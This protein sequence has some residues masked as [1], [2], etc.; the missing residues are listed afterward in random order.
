MAVDHSFWLKKIEK[1]DELYVLCS[2]YT[3]HPFVVC[4]EETFDDMAYIFTTAEMCRAFAQQF[5]TDKYVLHEVQIEK[6]MIPGVLTSFFLLGINAVMFQDEGAP[7]KIPLEE[8]A[9]KPDLEVPKNA[10]IPEAN[11]ELQLTGLYFMQELNRPGEKSAE[12]KIRLSELEAEMAHY[13][14]NSR[15]IVAF[16]VT[17]VKGDWNPEDPNQQVRV[18]IVSTPNGHKFQPVYTDYGEMQMFN[19]TAIGRKFKMTAVPYERLMEY[20]FKEAEGFV[21]NPGGFNLILTVDQMD[22]MARRY[23][24]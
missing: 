8:I 23:A 14:L 5:I 10:P 3:H 20:H 15:Y 6:E 12:E 17:D 9:M 7:V 1:L 24:E 21:I 13:L 2:E 19:R 18:P 22:E 11:P 4:D 16:D